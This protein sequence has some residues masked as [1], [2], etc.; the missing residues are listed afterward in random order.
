LSGGYPPVFRIQHPDKGSWIL[1][2]AEPC[3]PFLYY[4]MG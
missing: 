3:G 4:T 1:L 2:D